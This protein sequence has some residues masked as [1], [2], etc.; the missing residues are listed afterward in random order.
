VADNGHKHVFHLKK[1][2][3]DHAV[4][5]GKGH[6]GN[7]GRLTEE[8]LQ[9]AGFSEHQKEENH[10]GEEEKEIRWIVRSVNGELSSITGLMTIK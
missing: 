10:K 2:K 8:S 1:G 7:R 3:A 5:D 4:A 6:K 9:T